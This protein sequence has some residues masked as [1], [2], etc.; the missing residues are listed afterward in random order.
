MSTNNN[1]LGK[2]IQ[3][4]WI[5]S[6]KL[7]LIKVSGLK[8][9]RLISNSLEEITALPLK[10]CGIKEIDD[11]HGF[12]NLQR[13]DL[14]ENQLKRLKGMSDL[15]HLG[16]LN[17]SKNQL[18]GG[19]S[20]EDLRYL[21]QL[22]TLNIGENPKIK[23]LESHTIKPLS[24]LQALIA[25]DCGLSKA[26]FIKFCPLLNTLVLSKNKLNSFLKN[27]NNNDNPTTMTM[28]MTNFT[29]IHL[30]KL[31]LGHNQFTHIPNLSMCPN[32]TELRLNNNQILS[33]TS[34]ILI[35]SKLKIL[36]LSNNLLSSWSEVDI[37]TNLAQLTNLSLKGLSILLF[38]L[39]LSQYSFNTFFL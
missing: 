5:S 37:L 38:P 19:G 29:F 28:T 2:E 11:F 4:L 35:P 15:L 9:Q 17:I 33:I 25:N 20:C 3:P 34:E 31:S 16:M 21:T 14:S 39:S 8:I 13:L 1:R 32:L 30:T 27:N 22:R 24:K 12:N 7:K 36:D 23:H 6:E 26:S 18:D 10:D